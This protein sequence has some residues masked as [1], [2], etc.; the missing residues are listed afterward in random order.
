MGFLSVKPDLFSTKYKICLDLYLLGPSHTDDIGYIF[1]QPGE[2]EGSPEDLKVRE[3]LVNLWSSFAK[4]GVPETGTEVKWTPISASSFPYLS[5]DTEIN[6][7]EDFQ[8][9]KMQFWNEIGYHSV[10]NRLNIEEVIPHL[11]GRRVENHSGKAT[12][13]SPER[14]SNLDL[15]VLGGLVQHETSALANYATEA[16]NDSSPFAQVGVTVMEGSH[17]FAAGGTTVITGNLY[18]WR[19]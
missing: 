13:S 7:E 11:L 10:D 19:T 14:D 3:N 4:T 1:Y 18:Q 6:M 17:V 9:E 5:I 12:P 16:A 2:I 8:K 15:P